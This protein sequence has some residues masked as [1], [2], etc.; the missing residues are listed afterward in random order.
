[1]SGTFVDTSGWGNLVDPTQAFH[2]QAAT[3]YR[4]TR[5]QGS[6][7]VTTNYILTE[8]VALLTSPVRVP[9]RKVIE[10]SRA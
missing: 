8:L 3:L 7:L 5:Q 4:Q 9:R 1:M 10:L 6:R 2:S